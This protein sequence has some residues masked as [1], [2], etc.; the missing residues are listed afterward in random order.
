MN[1]DARNALEATA[2]SAA[3]K[4][5][6]GSAAG[7]F[8]GFISSSAFI[9]LVSLAIGL[10]GLIV[11]VYFKARGDRRAQEEHDAWMKKLMKDSAPAELDK[12]RQKDGD[13]ES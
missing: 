3:S 7:G 12:L 9:S 6:I 4:V 10:V 2:A 8:L 13:S 1:E 11:T 5:T